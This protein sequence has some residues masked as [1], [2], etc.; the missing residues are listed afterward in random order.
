MRESAACEMNTAAHEFHVVGVRV[1]AIQLDGAV[2]Q[3]ERLIESRETGRYVAVTGMHGIAES[4][5]DACFREILNKAALV[6]PD[7]MPL[8]WLG[9]WHGHSLR[10]RV[11]GSELMLA[12][13]QETG[14]RRRHFFY[15]G[16]PEWRRI[17]HVDCTSSSALRS[18]APIRL[19]FA[20][21][22]KRKIS[23]SPSR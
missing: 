14:S 6:V 16:A 23:R 15:G 4:R 22:R 17:W 2:A 1:H 3:I 5:Q 21:L 11:T 12:Y 20:P 19:R 9:R 8:L 18:P 7:G 10:R 13:C